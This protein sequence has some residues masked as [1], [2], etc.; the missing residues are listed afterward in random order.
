MI[1]SHKH[2][3]IF[4]KTNKTAGTSIEIALSKVC[5]PDDVITPITAEDEATR[6]SLGYT[7][8]QNCT[9]RNGVEFFHHMS[10]ASIKEGVDQKVWDQYY[11]F[12]F[13]RNPW[14]RMISMYYWRNKSW[15]RTSI[16]KFLQTDAPSVLTKRGYDLYSING[17]IV[18]DRVCRFES[19][20]QDLEEVC[21]HL[22]ITES[23]E[24][25]RAKSRYRKD[26]SHYKDILS[27]KESKKI[28]EMF[29]REIELF[30][31]TY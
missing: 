30:G 12:C 6:R 17:R 25:P 28:A 18:V 19:I 3:F 23:L 22:G 7:G 1:I 13:E 9:G 29:H 31:Y 10:A 27:E 5:G 11:K 15:P 21:L 14:D 2:K 26:K 8:P 20:A 24:L 4:I 16:A